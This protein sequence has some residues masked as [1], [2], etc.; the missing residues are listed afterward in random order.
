MSRNFMSSTIGITPAKGTIH[1]LHWPYLD[2]KVVH[3]DAFHKKSLL[4]DSFNSMPFGYVDSIGKFFR[5]SASD[6]FDISKR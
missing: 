6:I 4:I 1:P 5:A 3:Q 2:L